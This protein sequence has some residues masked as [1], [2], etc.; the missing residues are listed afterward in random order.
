[1]FSLSGKTVYPVNGCSCGVLHSFSLFSLPSLHEE[2]VFLI[3]FFPKWDFIMWIHGIQCLKIHVGHEVPHMFGERSIFIYRAG[4][5]IVGLVDFHLKDP[6]E[7]VAIAMTWC[8]WILVTQQP[9]CER[10]GTWSA[11][12]EEPLPSHLEGWTMG[13]LNFCSGVMWI[14]I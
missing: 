3:T 7:L 4:G 14:P 2:C 8:T 6:V 9:L 1:M 5:L 13:N 10:R 12:C 11:P